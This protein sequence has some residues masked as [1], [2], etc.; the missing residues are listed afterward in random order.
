MGLV[1]FERGRRAPCAGVCFCRISCGVVLG[2]VKTRTG[3]NVHDWRIERAHQ[4]RKGYGVGAQHCFTLRFGGCGGGGVYTAAFFTSRV[5]VVSHRQR[6]LQA[7]Q[8]FLL[9]SLSLTHTHAPANNILN[10]RFGCG[11]GARQQMG[12]TQNRVSSWICISGW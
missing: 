12:G 5:E 9:L 11:H 3:R 2:A 7:G 8:A 1:D 6:P 10:V 4:E